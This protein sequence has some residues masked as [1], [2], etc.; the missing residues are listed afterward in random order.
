MVQ[1][2]ILELELH[3]DDVSS[4]KIVLCQ[5]SWTL[6]LQVRYSPKSQTETGTPC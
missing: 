6:E 4:R 3:G 2:K 1:E 5:A